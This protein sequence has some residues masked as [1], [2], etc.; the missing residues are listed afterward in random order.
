MGSDETLRRRGVPGSSFLWPGPWKHLG[1]HTPISPEVGSQAPGQSQ[2]EGSERPS[3]TG[4]QPLCVCT[5]VI[6]C[7]VLS[8]IPSH[9]SPGNRLRGLFPV[10]LG[11]PVVPREMVLSAPSPAIPSVR[12]Q[13][14]GPS[15]PQSKPCG[16][17]L[18]VGC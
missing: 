4:S 9:P 8:Q 16:L 7:L 18:D 2:V 10:S 3:T 17:G 6:S 1:P 13:E 11:C 14:P 5:A 15:G 12:D